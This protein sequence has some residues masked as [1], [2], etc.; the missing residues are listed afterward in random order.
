MNNKGKRIVG[1]T[2]WLLLG[3]V[4]RLILHFAIN[5]LIARYLGPSGMGA[6]NY[7]ASYTTFFTSVCSLGLNGV[8]IHEI[9]NH[10][11][12]DGEI[13]GTAIFMRLVVGCVSATAMVLLVFVLDGSDKNLIIMAVLQAVQLPF[14]AFDSVKYWY[15]RKLESKI[16]V[17][18]TVIA[19]AFS[20]AVKI[21]LIVLKLNYIWF[22]LGTTVD[23]CFVGVLY[24]FSYQ[25]RKTQRLAINR[26][27]ARRMLRACGPFLLANITTFIYTRI[28][29]IMI[30][31]MLGS[32]EAVGY[33]S[34]AITICGYIA[35]VPTAVLDSMR[36]VIMEEK[37]QNE[38]SYE[39][40]VRQLI[41]LIM[42]TALTYSA[43]V[44]LLGKEI[45]TI[46]YGVSYLG[47]LRSLK[48]A[49]WFDAFSYLGGIKS[50]WLL[51]E[52]KN[53]YVLILSV[54]GGATNVVCN[55][56]MIP[57]WGIE[58]A[59]IATLLTQVFSNIFYPLFF[60]DTRKF[61]MCTFDGLFLRWVDIK[62]IGA[63]LKR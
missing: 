49:V 5:I 14:A 63:K 47:A 20:A 13:V 43:V 25:K 58:G 4:F 12:D 29:T 28:D 10:P 42:W 30:K 50:V 48:I 24:Y 40:K 21:A 46:L 59:A 56:L 35:F 62:E 34:T 52:N 17:K 54:L 7:I 57:V 16:D 60:K 27:I 23:V 51:C 45:I 61:F 33:Y 36:P 39:R 44:T 15:Q 19:F 31:Q 26:S 55:A 18:I 9:V 38:S 11:D 32:T 8:I 2:L 6:V 37:N 22:A 53:R 3:S 41:T 1:N